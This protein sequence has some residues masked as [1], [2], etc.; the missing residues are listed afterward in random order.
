MI[1]YFDEIKD[2]NIS[3]NEILEQK[4]EKKQRCLIKDIDKKKMLIG[5]YFTTSN[6]S[7]FDSIWHITHLNS[8][9]ILYGETINMQKKYLYDKT[10][11]D[12]YYYEDSNL[13]FLYKEDTNQFDVKEVDETSFN[14]VKNNILSFITSYHSIKLHI[15]NCS[16]EKIAIH[17][18]Y[19][20]ESAFNSD[21]FDKDMKIEDILAQIKKHN[22]NEQ[23]KVKNKYEDLKENCINKLFAHPNGFLVINDIDLEKNGYKHHIKI[24]TTSF[25]L[26]LHSS[27]KKIEI[28]TDTT[29]SLREL[30]S[31][32]SL[33]K[34]FDTSQI[35][36]FI[37][38]ISSYKIKINL[39]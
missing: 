20:S 24:N 34:Y 29:L 36:S 7:F 35:K 16:P 38:A 26:K 12:C 30:P 8:D 33:P 15:T 2:K 4:N 5:K 28:V 17:Y 31:L 3:L 1:L 32:F 39:R 18:D 37:T 21:N 23:L 25:N 6:D 22:I 11:I 19:L 9:G 13:D 14:N 10:Y 27:F